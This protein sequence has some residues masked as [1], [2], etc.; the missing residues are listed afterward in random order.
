LKKLVIAMLFLGI[1]IS[2]TVQ[3]NPSESIQAEAMKLERMWW[4]QVKNVDM[5]GLKKQS[6]QIINKY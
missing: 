3:A 4:D 5:D 2:A 6:H 1:S